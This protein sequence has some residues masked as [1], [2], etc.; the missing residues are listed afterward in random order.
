MTTT[1]LGFPLPNRWRYLR[2]FGPS[3]AA[4]TDTKTGMT[5]IETISDVSDSDQDWHHL[6]MAH[7]DHVPTYDEMKLCKAVFIGDAHTSM[8]FFPAKSRH[9]NI[10]EYCLH[11]W[12]PMDHDITP[13]FGQEGTI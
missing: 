7:E 3:G 2:R 12:T 11:L 13:D 1:L 9:V 10:H 8:Q 4:Y 5:I 6:S